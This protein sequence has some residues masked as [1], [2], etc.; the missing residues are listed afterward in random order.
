MVST[1]SKNTEYDADSK[2]TEK[3]AKKS[4]YKKVIFINK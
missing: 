2:S 1:V 4:F 3:V